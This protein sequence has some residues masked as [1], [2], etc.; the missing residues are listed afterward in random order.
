M[1]PD[2]L[3][4]AAVLG[5]EIDYFA[6]PQGSPE[7]VSMRAGRF[8]A[9]EAAAMLGLSPYETRAAMLARKATGVE[10]EHDEHTLRIFANGHAVEAAIRPHVEQIIGDDLSPVTCIRRGTK[11]VA[12]CDGLTLMRDWAWENKQWAE[13]LA[14][15]VRAGAVPDSHMPQ[16]QQ[17]L[18][19]TGAERLL[20]TVTDGTPERTVSCEVLPDL[21]WFDRIVLGW[22]QFERDLAAYV[23]PESQQ[24]I[25]PAAQEH[26]P[27]VSVQVSGS[28]A[29]LS[30]LADLKPR[31]ADYIERIPKRPS[32]DQEFA[33]VGAAGKRL[34]EVQAAVENAVNGAL[35]SI[36]D[37]N[38]L[39]RI[40][41]ELAEMARQA[42]ISCERAEASGKEAVKQRETIAR[43]EAMD[44]HL[45]AANTRLG[46][47]YITGSFA[48]F[49]SVIKG[50]KTLASVRDKLDTELARA[51]IEC[52][53]LEHRI[54]ANLATLAAAG[55]EHQALFADRGQL[56]HKDP[57]AVQ[58]IVS[59]RVAEHRAAEDRRLAAERERIRIEE[60]AK[61][62]AAAAAQVPAAQ[63]AEAAR[64]GGGTPPL[65]TPAPIVLRPSGQEPVV[66]LTDLCSMVGDGFSLTA[67]WVRARGIPVHKTER[68]SEHRGALVIARAD[69]PRLRAHVLAGLSLWD[70]QPEV[71]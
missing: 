61:A 54:A 51:K 19:V 67:D 17:V 20:F 27:A 39:Q 7:W 55:P 42:A 40:G 28:L 23:Q 26:L 66:K 68:T 69:V 2:A 10:P 36:A 15:Q 1:N 21:Q 48:S 24:V 53:Q 22:A 34:R 4:L 25:V 50:L 45:R 58:A 12:S 35:A 71:V 46:G 43:A 8:G 41:K 56:V 13:R 49:G 16:C 5:A 52:D 14:E 47:A 59:Q 44:A 70:R 9:S 62:Q 18:L 11:L 33:D 29:V 6:G 64:P 30:N 60:A 32:T 63:V 38:E 37:V 65:G 3:P 31:L 57:E